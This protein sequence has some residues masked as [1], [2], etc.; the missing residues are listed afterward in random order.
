MLMLETLIMLFIQTG[1]NLSAEVL[2]SKSVMKKIYH[3]FHYLHG[4]WPIW[5]WWLY[6][7]CWYFLLVQTEMI[8]KHIWGRTSRRKSYTKILGKNLSWWRCFRRFSCA[9]LLSPHKNQLRN[10]ALSVHQTKRP[11]IK[12]WYLWRSS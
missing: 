12:Y 7:W 6:C 3:M 8:R 10:T 9:I 5:I 1:F 11:M 4:G 2:R